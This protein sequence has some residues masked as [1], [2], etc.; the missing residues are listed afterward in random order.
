[1]KVRDLTITKVIVVP[2]ELRDTP[3]RVV[4]KNQSRQT[5]L[6]LK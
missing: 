6:P 3:L 2:P 5:N 4:K 1:M